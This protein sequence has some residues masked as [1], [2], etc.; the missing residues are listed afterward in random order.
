[1]D[2]DIVRIIHT[3]HQDVFYEFES[4]NFKKEWNF[5]DKEAMIGKIFQSAIALRDSRFYEFRS[6]FLDY[7][8]FPIPE[9]KNVSISKQDF[10]DKMQ[11]YLKEKYDYQTTVHG[12]N[13]TGDFIQFLAI[14]F[15]ET[16]LHALLP[17]EI[18]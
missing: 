11:N 18:I 12:W 4:P 5:E 1:M 9:L 17:K 13:N 10:F 8:N 15:Y 16:T 6:L 3:H 14:L 7:P 2:M